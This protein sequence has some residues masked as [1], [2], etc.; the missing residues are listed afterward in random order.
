MT[1][2]NG[3]LLSLA[4]VSLELGG[5]PILES[6]DLAIA[7][8]EILTIIGPNGAGKTSLLRVALGLTP[9]TGGR[10]IT[11]PGLRVGYMPQRLQVDPSLPLTVNRFLNLTAHH[12]RAAKS[13]ALAEVGGVDLF[14]APLKG[15]SGGELQRVMLARV[16]LARPDLLVLDEPVQ[17]VDVQ[18]QVELYQLLTRIRERHGCAILL[19]SHDLHLVMASTDRVVC[20]NQHIC[21]TGSPE[22]VSHNPAFLQLF[23]RLAVENLAVYSHDQEHQHGH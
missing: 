12:K 14:F 11:R 16:L 13:A 5:R 3:P 18:G 17:G 15:L 21:C 20:L 23:G 7:P 2:E 8:A 1:R 22:M 4:G 10:V 19:V 6:V 9:P